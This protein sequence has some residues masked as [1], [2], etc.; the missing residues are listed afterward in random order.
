MSGQQQ[1]G[2]SS[3]SP[4]SAQVT[5]N[6]RV[7]RRTGA[8][9]PLELQM[10][11]PPTP[12][13]TSSPA[14]ALSDMFD[15]RFPAQTHDTTSIYM[16]AQR[17][18][19]MHK[20]QVQRRSSTNVPP[21]KS[22]LSKS[23]PS[24]PT[25]VKRKVSFAD[26]KGLSLTEVRVMQNEI[27]E[28][29]RWTQAFICQNFPARVESN[30]VQTWDP[31]FPQP[32]SDYLAFRKRID[33]QL[34]ALENVI[35][36]KDDDLLTG[37]I[38]VKNI[39]FEKHVFVR[40]TFDSWASYCDYPAMFV[41]QGASALPAM[42][43][44]F[45][46]SIKVPASAQR[47]GLIEICIAYK[48]PKGEYWDN[49]NGKNYKLASISRRTSDVTTTHVMPAPPFIQPK[50]ASAFSNSTTRDWS[51]FSSWNQILSQGPYW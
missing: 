34:V 13:A 33:D 4:P 27:N 19:R 49:N 22:C 45:S 9:M 12:L 41:S 48:T 26:D 14:A 7:R 2:D 29:P 17:Q 8:N 3:R 16:A 6:P 5:D 1:S 46:F 18:L 37:T 32:A 36:R 15:V 28:L 38:K 10:R 42:F 39:T 40:A 50:F 44:T 30:V 25:K 11:L 47:Y 35:V 31:L 23:E 21:S 51:D 43:D 20:E 24:S